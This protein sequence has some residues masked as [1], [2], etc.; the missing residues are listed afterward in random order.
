MMKSCRSGVFFPMKNPS[1]WSVSCMCASDT[2]SSRIDSP[3]KPLNSPAEISPRPLNRVTSA[4]APKCVRA[5]R[6]SGSEYQ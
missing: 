1:S 2:G 6:L 4:L 5:A 3:M